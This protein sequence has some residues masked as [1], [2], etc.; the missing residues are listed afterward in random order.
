MLWLS[1][2]FKAKIPTSTTSMSTFWYLQM[3]DIH[4]S[5]DTHCFTCATNNQSIQIQQNKNHILQGFK[6]QVA[7]VFPA[8][9]DSR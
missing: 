6:H 7:E 2:C 9:Y 4:D 8:K 3:Q 5:V 1:F